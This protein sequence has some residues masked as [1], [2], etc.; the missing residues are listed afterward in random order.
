MFKGC[1]LFI[2]LLLNAL[3]QAQQTKIIFDHY[4]LEAGF[5]SR[6]ASHI[7]TTPNSM[8]WVSSNDGLA[9]FD[10]KRFKFY[11]HI[12]GDTFSISN[13]YCQALAT[14]KRGLIWVQSDNNLDVF[15]PSTERF[16]HI[17]LADTGT[18]RR[19]VYPH[20]FV[21]DSA[22]DIMWV[23]TIKGLYFSKQGRHSLQSITELSSEKLLVSSHIGTLA[24]ESSQFLWVTVGNQIIRLNTKNGQT[25]KFATPGRVD[26]FYNDPKT[27]HFISAYLAGN[28]TLWLGTWLKG[29]FSFNTETFTFHQYC[30]RDYTK[31]ENSIS[32]IIQTHEPGQEQKLWLTTA[33]YGLATFD[34]GLKKFTSYHSAGTND[35][36]GITGS[37]YGLHA[38]GKKGLWIGSESGLHY[39][40]YNKQLFTTL[41]ISSIE[42]GTQL[43]PVSNMAVQKNEK[44]KDEI[45]WFYIPYKGGYL[46]DLLLNKIK[47]LPPKVARYINMPSDFLRFFMDKKN[48]LWI[49][50]VS[51]G[52]VGY[53][54]QRDI[55]IFKEAILFSET[56]KWIWSFFEDRQSRLWLGSFNGLYVLDSSRKTARAVEVV[57]NSL[58]LNGL[59]KKIFEMT[60]DETGNIWFIADGTDSKI[61]C[62]GKLNPTNDSLQYIYNEK[63]RQSINHNPV[64]L[65][66][67]VHNGKGKIFVSFNGE[68]VAWFNSKKVDS[69][70]HFFT[71]VN[72]LSSNRTNGLIAD[73]NCNIWC[74]TSFGF[75]AYKEA[76]HVFTNYNYT[77]YA[78]DNTQG[79]FL[80]LS[81]Q[82]D[83][84]YVGQSNAIRYFNTSI[85]N[86][87]VEKKQLVFTEMKVL[88]TPFNPNG[89][90]LSNGDVITLTHKQDMVSIEFALLS[91]TNSEENTYSW[92]LEGWDKYWNTSKNNIAS[93]IHLEPGTYTLW[94]KAANSQGEWTK[95]PI[96]LTLK[97]AY[98]FYQKSWFIALCILAL[99]G[100]IYGFFQLR[101]RRIKEKYQFRN[102][103]AADLH[104]EI[105]STLTS[106]NILS[107]VSQQAMDL[108]PQQAKEMMQQISSQSKTIQ[109]SMSDIVWSI[110]PD[111]DKVEDLVTRMREYAGQTLEQL[112]INAAI[113]ADEELAA[114]TLPMQYRKELL[115]IYKEA[116][117]NIAKH[118]GASRVFVSLASENKYLKLSIV[119]NG[120][121][122]GTT[123]GTGSHSMKARAVAM[124]GTLSILPSETGTEVL[125]IIPVP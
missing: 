67:I 73:K 118:A 120:K 17:T 47:P 39:Y 83:R 24:L 6:E 55:I 79:P 105:G 58:E 89:R 43:L 53:D 29:L 72:E 49:S 104:D 9:R 19:P 123:T 70:P 36:Y 65:G 61:A 62:I 84:V 63:T 15:D 98:P 60:E 1:L 54:I 48:V 13:N 102:E 121:W 33:D 57:N 45:L 8:V 100:I 5:N 91:Y 68:G 78:L 34:M 114:K 52:L 96:R 25:E 99:A 87:A 82:S 109:Q 14:D 28:R 119:D 27:L 106:I 40:D 7:V 32:A 4:G 101:I 122:K 42:K 50:T 113:E 46:Y 64:E 16:S 75:S 35:P 81:S 85:G 88:N 71:T 44:H 110:R 103:I 3:L 69:V 18:G 74:S 93:Y 12:E 77:S 10:S 108:Q 92:M 80:Y 66:N 23:A 124:G 111:N 31:E 115:L 86:A 20:K 21:Y 22:S 94:V 97:I 90:L 125:A 37:T 112:G 95:E 30:F 11:K 76:Q 2:S 26:G 51:D 59:A 117:N 56:K 41:D 38:D 116:I 107:H